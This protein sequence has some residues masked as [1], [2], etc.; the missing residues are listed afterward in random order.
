MMSNDKDI[1]NSSLVLLPHVLQN[2]QKILWIKHKMRH[3]FYPEPYHNLHATLNQVN[4]ESLV[5]S[6]I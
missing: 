5:I 2:E 4:D 6:G 1:Q 3:S